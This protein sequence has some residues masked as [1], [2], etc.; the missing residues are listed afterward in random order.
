MLRTAGDPVMTVGDM[1]WIPIGFS[2]FKDL[3]IL[4]MNQNGLRALCNILGIPSVA[5]NDPSGAQHWNLSDSRKMVYTNRLIPDM[6]LLLN[7]I[8]IDIAPA[9]GKEILVPDYSQIPELQDA[10]KDLATWLEAAVR[11][12]LPPNDMFE[13]LGLGRVDNAE[14]DKSYLPFNIMPV[15]SVKMTDEEAEKILKNNNI[16]DY[17]YLRAI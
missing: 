7:H 17:K 12:G 10:K 13:K 14:L 3:Q 6:N 11:W 2:N 15:E 1:K 8:N 5:F 9:Y 16:D 4:E